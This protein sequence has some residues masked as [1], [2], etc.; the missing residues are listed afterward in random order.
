MEL[1]EQENRDIYQV[2]RKTIL[3]FFIVIGAL[4]IISGLMA[5]AGQFLP[6]SNIINKVLDLPFAFVATL[7]GLSNFKIASNSKYKKIYWLITAILLLL[8]FAI[9][10]YIIAFIPDKIS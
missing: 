1:I 5:S 6:I 4:H 3:V 10:V 2:F 9:M 7:F 8:V